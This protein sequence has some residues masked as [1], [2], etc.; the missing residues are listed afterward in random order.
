MIAKDSEKGMF[1]KSDSVSALTKMSVC[2]TL[3][4]VMI[5]TKYKETLMYVLV[6]PINGY[7]FLGTDFATS[8][9]GDTIALTISLGEMFSLCTLNRSYKLGG[10]GSEIITLKFMLGSTD[11]HL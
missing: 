2:L 3:I 6:L 5:S 11:Y 4:L 8:S 9:V 1:V 7:N 10:S